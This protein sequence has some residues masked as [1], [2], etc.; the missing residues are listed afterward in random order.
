MKFGTWVD[1]AGH[2]F[3]TTHFPNSLTR[4]PFRGKGVYHLRGKVTLDFGFPA[5]E[6]DWMERLPFRKD[7]RY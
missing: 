2:F 6:V 5:L 3:D 4:Y 1:E 7:E